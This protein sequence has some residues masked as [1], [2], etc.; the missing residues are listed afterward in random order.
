MVI[1]AFDPNHKDLVVFN[2]KTGVLLKDIESV[3][4]EKKIVTI[5]LPVENRTPEEIDQYLFSQ[6]GKHELLS[7]GHQRLIQFVTIKIRCE[8][9]GVI[10]KDDDPY[11][12][13]QCPDFMDFKFFKEKVIPAMKVA[14][15]LGKPIPIESFYKYC[16]Y[17]KYN[18]R[19]EKG[20]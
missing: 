5:V 13:I 15:G 9:V 20:Y 3:D 18:F 7:R 11:D 17:P 1:S 6:F 4:T 8:N 10:T 12:F 19:L 2:K 14:R 16:K